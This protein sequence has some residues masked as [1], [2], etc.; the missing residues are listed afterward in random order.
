MVSST[1]LLTASFYARNVSDDLLPTT[2]LQT[3]FADGSRQTRT[4]GGKVDWFQSIG[5]H[6]LKAGMDAS[7]YRLREGFDFDP[8]RAN[9]DDLNGDNGDALLVPLSN[10]EGL[11]GEHLDEGDEHHGG[12]EGF[13]FSGRE[14]NQLVSA[15]VQDRFNP[16]ANLTVDVGV[17]LDHLNAVDSHTEVSPRVGLVYHFPR[18]ASVVRFAYNRLFTPQPIEYLLLA[19][20]LGNASQDERDRTGNVKPYTQHHFEGG[21]SQQVH[22][23]VVVDVGAYR[24]EG[25][26]AFE[27][28]EISDTRLF[29]PTN[30]ADARAY[31]LELG[32]DYRPAAVSGFSGRVQYALAKVEFIGPVSGGFAAEAHGPGEAIPPAFDQRHTLVSNVLYR[33][34]WRGFTVGAVTRYGSGTPSEQHHDDSG[35]ATFV[36]LPDHW[37]FDFNARVNLWQQGSRRLAFEFDVTN[38]TNNIYA[39]AKESEAT[40]LQYATPRVVGARLRVDF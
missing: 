2:D 10:D 20:F 29:V 32:L 9:D 40:P 6:R 34:P 8:R 21:L 13:A 15:Y 19:N 14:T 12:L 37:T 35:L 7:G 33:Q 24:H 27:T 5:G 38:L 16:A 39:I 30:F 23:N 26:H 22:D 1:S 25:K 4:L 3:T 28:S 11:E 18:S 17:R 31:G 36:H